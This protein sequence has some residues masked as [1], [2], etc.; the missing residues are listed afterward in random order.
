MFSRDL[1]FAQ[2]ILWRRGIDDV[3]SI[4]FKDGSFGKNNGLE[5]VDGPLAGLHSSFIVWIV[6]VPFYT[7]SKLEK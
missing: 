5:I 4:G 6:M 3:I 1:P 2:K 7:Q